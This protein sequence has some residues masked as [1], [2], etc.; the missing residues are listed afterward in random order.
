[1]GVQ[2]DSQEMEE[3][4]KSS[5]TL[6]LATTRKSGEPF[7]TPLW[8]AYHDG[9]IYI[10]TPMKSAKVQHIKRDSRVCCMVEEGERWID[11]K[12]VVLNCDAEIVDDEEIAKKVAEITEEKYREFRSQLKAAPKATKKHYSGSSALIKLVPRDGEVRSWYNQKIR[13]MREA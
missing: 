13:G 10:R 3:F 8:Y 11:L 7:L 12:A 6:V 4:L 9:A 2:L 1:M 5:H